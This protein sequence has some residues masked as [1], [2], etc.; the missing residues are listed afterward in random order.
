MSFL[1]QRVNIC[2]D[3]WRLSEAIGVQPPEGDETR[4]DYLDHEE[5]TSAVGVADLPQI[6][7]DQVQ[8]PGGCEHVRRLGM[9]QIKQRMSSR[10][11][12]CSLS[13]SIV[14]H[15]ISEAVWVHRRWLRAS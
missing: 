13:T 8:L 12:S 10:T 11:V 1:F 5:S 15:A 3:L 4:A 9:A 6:L 2:G 7:E 14:G